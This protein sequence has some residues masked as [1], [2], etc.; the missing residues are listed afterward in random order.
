MKISIDSEVGLILF[1]ESYDIDE[2]DTL[3]S[4]LDSDKLK[5][6][7]HI[8]IDASKL[9]SINIIGGELFLL[10]EKLKDPIQGELVFC[11]LS[12]SFEQILSTFGEQYSFNKMKKFNRR[13]EALE[14]LESLKN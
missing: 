6:L 4:F 14:Y 7:N 2:L 3:M 9:T 1:S 5:N 12:K 13:E 11:G 8:L 10:K